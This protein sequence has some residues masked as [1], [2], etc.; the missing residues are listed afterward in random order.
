MAFGSHTVY[1]IITIIP[2]LHCVIPHHSEHIVGATSDV[3]IKLLVY[4]YVVLRATVAASSKR[5][6][7]GETYPWSSTVFYSM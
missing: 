4:H 1:P 3:D 5:D 7:S 2:E 6:H